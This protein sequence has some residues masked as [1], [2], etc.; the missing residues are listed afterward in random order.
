MIE[1][2]GLEFNRLTNSFIHFFFF[3]EGALSSHQE[4]GDGTGRITGVYTIAGPDGRERRV[5]YIADADGYRATIKTNE[6]GTA[7]G[8]DS[9]DARWQVSQPSEA[10]LAAANN[11]NSLN[12]NSSANRPSAARPNGANNDNQLPE[13][14][15]ANSLARQ[16]TQQQE[17]IPSSSNNQANAIAQAPAE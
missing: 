15:N 3:T 7:P 12:P 6:I 17:Q 14:S 5:E 2:V 1:S 9:G 4:T 16:P 8:S 11:A 13:G 10:Q